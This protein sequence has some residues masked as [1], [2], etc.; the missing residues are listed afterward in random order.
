MKS[1]LTFNLCFFLF[2]FIANTVQAAPY[3]PVEEGAKTERLSLE[4]AE[5][6]AKI[7][8]LKKERRKQ[9]RV[10]KLLQKIE[11]R[12]EKKQQKR[13]RYGDIWDDLKFRAGVLLLAVALGLAIVAAIIDIIGIIGFLSG[14]FALAGLIL[15]IWSLVEYFS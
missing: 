11:K 2:F 5:R 6:Q 14:L 15:L 9:S 12:I 1:L 7:R 4:K 10:K 3:L 8:H 13:S